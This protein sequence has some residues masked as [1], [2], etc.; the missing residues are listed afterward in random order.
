MAVLPLRPPR[1]LVFVFAVAG[2]ALVD[3][4]RGG[5]IRDDR[6]PALYTALGADPAYQAVGLVS[7]DVFEEGQPAIGSGTL[8][9]PDWVMTA[10][11]VV[12][13]GKAVRFDVGGQT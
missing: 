8:I 12:E 10:A 7:V 9:S 4:A 13:G 6:D 1:T 3:V 2:A 11:H 5:T